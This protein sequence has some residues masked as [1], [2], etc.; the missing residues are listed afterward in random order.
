MIAVPVSTKAKPLT[1]IDFM[2]P[3]EQ[4]ASITEVQDYAGRVPLKVRSDERFTRAVAK[5]LAAIKGQKAA[6]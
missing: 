1:A 5:R 2:V 4:C 3:L 6:A